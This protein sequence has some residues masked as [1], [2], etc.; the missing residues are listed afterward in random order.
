LWSD[1]DGGWWARGRGCGDAFVSAEEA[2][3]R[4]VGRHL[5]DDEV[6][7]ARILDQ[8]Y[9]SEINVR[10]TRTAAGWLGEIGNEWNG[11]A[12]TAP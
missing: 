10:V 7:L 4:A 2:L 12:A 8:L 5:T 3:A 1:W 9:S 6:A 11:F